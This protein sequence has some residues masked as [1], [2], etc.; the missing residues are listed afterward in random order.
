MNNSEKLFNK[1]ASSLKRNILN[2]NSYLPENKRFIIDGVNVSGSLTYKDYI[3]FVESI[4]ASSY[5]SSPSERVSLMM[6]YA[7][8]D[9]QLNM[10]WLYQEIGMSLTTKKKDSKQLSDIARHKGLGVEQIPKKGI[11]I[12]G[13]ERR[14]RITTVSILSSLL[15]INADD[16]IIG[17]RANN[18]LEKRI[19]NYFLKQC[20]DVID[21]QRTLFRQFISDNQLRFSYPSRKFIYIYIIVSQ[22]RQLQ[23][24]YLTSEEDNHLDVQRYHYFNQPFEDALFDNLISSMD[25]L[26]GQHIANDSELQQLVSRFI[27]NIEQQIIT[28]FYTYQPLFDEVYRYLYKSIL[29]NQYHYNFYD[30]KLEDT[31]A[32]YP[33][34]YDIVS[35]SASMIEQRYA[36]VLTP[37]HLSTL[38]LIFRKF[39]MNNKVIGRN[40]Q[41]LVI[42]SNSA[43]DKISFFAEI[44]T[45]HVDITIVD[46][47]NIN[48]LHDIHRL[49][50]DFIVVFSNRIAM[51]LEENGLPCIK[52][53]FYLADSDVH[54]LLNLGFSASSRRKIPSDRFLA[55]IAG[56]SVE[57]I[58]TLLSEKYGSHFL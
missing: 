56:K 49:D 30:H 11:R 34:L 21:Q 8:L 36:I 42:V 48:E 27:G 19:I 29:R 50:Y 5:I 17:R 22:Y 55:D 51:L 57:E 58:R 45:H 20:Q 1:S 9:N 7:F 23:G 18:P 40:T 15:E 31:Q 32:N 53:N 39:I 43:I 2:I 38:T 25:H 26:T 16:Q 35:A 47:L 54:N 14:F 46:C 24:L 28:R 4:S 37:S 33:N 41:R 13:D 44:L 12:V 10:T 6:V 52:L 3:D